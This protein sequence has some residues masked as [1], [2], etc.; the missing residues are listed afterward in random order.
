MINVFFQTINNEGLNLMDSDGRPFKEVL[1]EQSKKLDLLTSDV[2]NL[3]KEVTN[4]IILSRDVSQH[5]CKAEELRRNIHGY[6]AAIEKLTRTIPGSKTEALR[7]LEFYMK[8]KH[9]S[10]RMLLELEQIKSV[11][12]QFASVCEN[13]RSQRNKVLVEI[14]ELTRAEEQYV[15][16]AAVCEALLGS[17]EKYY[18]GYDMVSFAN[19][20]YIFILFAY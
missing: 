6:S 7:N 13:D 18:T 11:L 5:L 1:I 8:L 12:G 20:I 14:S 17:A 4:K 3:A 10:E 9:E 2:L 15:Y 16:C 19:R